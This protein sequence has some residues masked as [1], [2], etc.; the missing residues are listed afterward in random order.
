MTPFLEHARQGR[1]IVVV[2]LGFLGDSVHLVPALW[3]IKR[4]CPQAQLHTLSAPV[5]AELLG[6]VPCVDRPWAFPLT[7][8]S[9]PWW[10]HWD[11]LL[12]LRRQRFDAAINFSGSDRSLFLTALTGA[13]W[14]LGCEAGRR[15]FWNS[16]L[17]PLWEPRQARHLPVFEQ[18]R[19][20]LAAQGF[21]LEAPRFDF[22]LSAESK[23]WAEANVAKQSIHLSI[24]ASMALKEWPLGHWIALINKLLATF[25][26]VSLCLTASA[27]AREQERLRQLAAEV[28]DE[29][30]RSFAGLHL[31]HL[32]ALLQRCRLHVGVDSG[33]LHLA[34]ALGRPTVTIFRQYDGLSEWAPAGPRHR[35]VS[36]PCHCN[37]VLQPACRASGQ[38]QC[39]AAITAEEVFAAV[40]A[41]AG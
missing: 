2:D 18:R 27:N 30:V 22:R 28:K 33:A 26:S 8:Q 35:M 15:H 7:P 39:L 9:P 19:Q 3:E 20:V 4:N 11:I 41:A 6:L 25:P 24:N 12:E 17:I 10:R 16:W 14:R 21:S 29:R 5:G 32:C 38:A 40:A 23:Q 1:K 34:M 37:K 31:G 13:R 36:A